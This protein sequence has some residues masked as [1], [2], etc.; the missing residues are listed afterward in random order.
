[1][2]NQVSGYKC[3]SMRSYK[4]LVKNKKKALKL[5]D[6]DVG[7]HFECLRWNDWLGAGP[8]LFFFKKESFFSFGNINETF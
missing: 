3:I 1:M 5:Y 8:I 4:I 6:I 2:K 7:H